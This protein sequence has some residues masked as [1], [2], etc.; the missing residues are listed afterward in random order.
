M[1]PQS[2]IGWF[3]REILGKPLYWYQEQI[4]DS[5]I[6]SVLAGQGH[7]FTVMMARQMGKNQLS[8]VLEAYFLFCMRQGSIVKAA[9]TYNPQI[10]NSRLRLLNMCEAPLLRERIWKSF[11][12]IVGCAPDPSQVAEQSGP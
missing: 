8:A 11:G 2:R 9:P 6:E 10:I 1:A 3:A 4:G 12:Y 5:I 7:T